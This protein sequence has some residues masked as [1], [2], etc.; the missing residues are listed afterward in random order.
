MQLHRG[1]ISVRSDGVGQGACF[2]VRLPLPALPDA[3][4]VQPAVRR[5]SSTQG[6]RLLVADDN[7]DSASTLQVLLDL[8][9][10]DVVV[11]NDGQ[12]ALDAAMREMPD[13]AILDIGMPGLNGYEVARRLRAERN[14]ASLGLIAI[15]GWGQ[16]SDKETAAAAGFDHH[17]VKPVAPEAV[18]DLLA[19]YQARKASRAELQATA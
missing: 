13:V 14:P 7:V 1:D 5:K 10:H 18:I 19:A 9:G 4:V 11:A 12:A 2:T 8:M 17:L 15:T 6:L 16:A 3:A